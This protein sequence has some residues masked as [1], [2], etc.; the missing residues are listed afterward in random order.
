VFDLI[1]VGYV[2]LDK[3]KIGDREFESCAVAYRDCGVSWRI[4]LDST[5]AAVI[6]K[7]NI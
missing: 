7:K 4:R 1:S 5:P 3:V 2:S 6:S